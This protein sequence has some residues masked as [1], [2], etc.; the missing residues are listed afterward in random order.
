MLVVKIKGFCPQHNAWPLQ[1]F[2]NR[3]AAMVLVDSTVIIAVVIKA[4]RSLIHY[5]A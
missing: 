1:A 4:L 5:F 2:S 3:S